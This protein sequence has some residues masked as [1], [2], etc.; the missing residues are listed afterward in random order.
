MRLHAFIL[1]LNASLVSSALAK[2]TASFSQ[3]INLMQDDIDLARSL[4]FRAYSPF[5][6]TL[7]VNKRG[8]VDFDAFLNDRIK[9]SVWRQ[10]PDPSAVLYASNQTITLTP[11]YNM[12]RPF[13]YRFAAV[14][15]EARHAE[16]TATGIGAW[17]HHRCDGNPY[18]FTI[19]GIK[20]WSVTSPFLTTASIPACDDSSQGAYAVG[21]AFLNA[22]A[23][24][25]TNCS[26]EL[27]SEAS[28]YAATALMRISDP[29][30]ARELIKN[31]SLNFSLALI[32]LKKELEK[33]E[34]LEKNH[35]YK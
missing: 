16:K 18:R 26:K 24:A 28:F 14:L 17:Q 13:V 5:F 23:E 35:F 11:S 1:L 9:R 34:W 25:C 21:F 4:S 7:F 33:I 27:R 8:K 2:K 32:R 6:R 22:V 15:H 29:H 30:A 12:D 31:A 10:K 20:N 19:A 3:T